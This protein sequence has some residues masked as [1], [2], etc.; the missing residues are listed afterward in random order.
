LG[1]RRHDSAGITGEETVF[2]RG[3]ESARIEE[4]MD[5][6]FGQDVHWQAS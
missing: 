2:D 4:T 3:Y 1:A 6:S 5:F